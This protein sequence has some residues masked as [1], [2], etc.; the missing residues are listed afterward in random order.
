MRWFDR[1]KM[2]IQM[3]VGRG[4][5]GTRLD[6]EL[7][8]HLDRQIAENIAAGMGREAARA[9]ALR[10][11]G[12][13]ALLREQ[14]RAAWSWNIL[15]QFLR[16]GRIAARTLRR[17]PGFTAVA[18]LVIALGIGANV[19]LFT[20]IRGVLLRPLPFKDPG[21]LLM[22]Y[23][24]S[25]FNGSQA[26]P[27]NLVAGGIY[28]AWNKEN[29]TF[30]RLALE[31]DSR[32]DLSASGGELPESLNSAIV[33]WNLFPT[34][35]VKPA[36]GRGFTSAE[37]SL[38]SSGTAVLSWSLW[39]RRFGGDPGILNKTIYLD[40]KPYTVIGIMPAWFQFPYSNTQ[41]WTP[42]NHD[43]PEKM[44]TSLDFHMYRVVGRPKPGVTAAEATANLT[45]ITRRIH[46]AHLADPFISVGANSKP[47]LDHMV[48]D[49]QR[50]LFVLFAATACLLLIACLNVANLLVARAAARRKELAIRT[51]M[52]GGRLRLLR[53]HLMESFLLSAA[54]G[55]AGLALAYGAITW[56]AHTRDNMARMGAIRIDAWVVV[57]TVGIIVLCTLFSGLVSALNAGDR[58]ILSALH[59]ASRANSAGTARTRLRKT[60]LAAE[61]GLTVVLLVAAT[62]L[63]KSYARLRSTDLGCITNNVLT[64]RINL[65]GARYKSPG[66]TPPAFFESLLQR[67][68]SL[69]GVEAAAFATAVPGQGYMGDLGFRIA[70]HPPL[71]RGKGTFTINRSVDPGYFAAMGIPILRGHIFD[72]GQ[73]FD[74]VNEAI[75]N[76]SFAQKYFPGEDPV[77]KHLLLLGG[78]KPYAIV[79]IVGDVRYSIGEQPAPIQYYPLSA[80]VPEGDQNFGMLVI[81]S[82]RDV[83]QLALPVQRILQSMD[84][85]VPVSDVLTMD[86]LLD[87]STLDQSFD[88]TI[89]GGFAILSLLLAAAGLFGVLSYTGAQRSSEIG[90]RI[91]LGAQRE[92]VLGLMLVEGMRPALIGLII[93]L[94]ASAATTRVIK[95]MLYGTQ[96]LDPPVF[97]AAAALLLAVAALACIFPAWRASRLDPMQ[98]LRAE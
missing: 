9:A 8:F 45:V 36:L 74:H 16:D 53:E 88:A 57:F 1:L 41:I 62:L 90:I 5:A 56:L 89:I 43:M 51:A 25:V 73:A 82:N 84:R 39:Q 67:V 17:T 7:Q 94:A 22:L 11:F 35:G 64:M 10:A 68:R 71:P 28:H 30:S 80:P 87:K 86:Q 32:T 55:A 18:I 23:E 3:L 24:N 26:F 31:R 92:Q 69:P 49:I 77:G 83:E 96:P 98:A 20:V 38:S 52:G 19:A 33:S 14:A 13:P 76:E 58:H 91:A 95:S 40:A 65:P 44:M 75:I 54:G 21:R 47:L 70:E 42:V 46:N 59:E 78:T 50:P 4:K 15:E 2:R 61:V 72:D 97:A 93:G 37:D 85:D 81:R 27:Y 6:D 34:L 60:L 12:N 66:P 29:D 48:G 63:L 79:G